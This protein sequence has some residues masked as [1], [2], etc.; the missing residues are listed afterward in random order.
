MTPLYRFFLVGYLISWLANTGV[1]QTKTESLISG[2]FSQV[3][4]SQF[5]QTVEAQT[6]YRFFYNPADTDSLIVN[7]RADKQPLQA[8]LTQLVAGTKFSYAID[9]QQQ[10]YITAGRPIRTQLPIGFFV[11]GATDDD[12]T[13]ATY[14]T[15]G[16]K[17]RAEPESRLYEI[18]KRTNPIRPGRATLAGYVRNVASG[19]PI[20]GA[21]IYI[22]NPRVGTASDQFGYYSLTLPRGR[23]ELKIRST[24]LKDTHRRIVLYAD[25]KFDIDLED[26]VIALKEVVIEAEKDV[27]ISG[28]QMG[29]ERVDIKSVKQIPTALGEADLLRVIQTLPGVKTVGESSTGLNVRGGATDQNLILYN[30]APIYNSSHLFGFFSAFN[31]DLIKSAELYKSA[32]PSRYGGRLSSVLDVQTRDGNK[33]KFI[34]SGGIGLLTG[35]LT[36]EGPILKDKTSFIAGIRTTYSDWLLKQLQN[37]AFRKSDAQFYDLNAHITH[38]IDEKNTIY[39]TGYLSRDRFTLGSDTAYSYQNKVATLKWKHVFSQKFYSV[40]T[41]SHSGYEYRVSSVLNPVN[42]YQLDFGINQ[43]QV[44]ADFNLY[45][46]NQHAV[47]FGISSIF[48]KLRPGTFQ[49]QGAESLIVPMSVGTEQGL[50]SAVYVGDR[51]DISPR[52]SVSGGLRYSFF[53]YLGPRNG[54]QYVPGEPRTIDNITDTIAYGRNQVINNYGGPEYRLALRYALSSSASVKASFNRTRQ[55]IQMLSNTTVISPTDI[56]KLSDANIKPQVGDQFAVG[57][58]KN[59]RTNTIELSVEAYYK[60]MRNLIDFR[61]GATLLLNPHIETDVVA[62]E[63]K[64]YGVEVLVKKMTGK[65]NGWLSYTYAR[66]FLRT[67]GQAEPDVINQGQY[68]PSSFD[69]PHD[70]TLISNYK[71]NRRFSLSLNVTYSTGRPIT[72][73]IAKYTVDNA[74]RLLYSERNQHRIPDYYRADFAMNIEGNHKVRKLAHSSWTIAVYN[75]TGRRNAYSVYFKSEN[76][77]IN[78]YQLSIFGQPIPSITYNFRF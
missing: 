32:M 21:A 37:A 17:Q 52:L 73:P 31:P 14:L 54:F 10:V 77:S 18:G 12:T 60:T 6:S 66:T 78:G 45:P 76:G 57:V 72:L 1:A 29:Q 30:D 63:G 25:G 56:W 59:N 36:V 38:E 9:N 3:R 11:R 23:H 42:A 27:N 74:L 19:E 49:P 65:L 43:S 20:V 70:V 71:I 5:V 58:Y 46:T 68:Y 22:D 64:A 62:A 51:F 8:L 13:G 50:E 48:Y 41:A 26:D 15:A 53:Q 75:L 4:F 28:L 16:P 44:K 24:G 39:L 40:Y 61:N 34:G 7:L 2:D 47:D 67:T 33:K 55:Y 35:R 69:K